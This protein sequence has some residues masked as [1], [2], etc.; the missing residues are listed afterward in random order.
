VFLGVPRGVLQI[1]RTLKA[2]GAEVSLKEL[3]QWN[4]CTFTKHWL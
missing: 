4:Y 1:Q 2:A 3:D